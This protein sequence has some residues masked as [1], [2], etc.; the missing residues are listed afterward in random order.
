MAEI[1]IDLLR[2]RLHRV[3]EREG[4]QESDAL[5]DSLHQLQIALQQ[6][7]MMMIVEIPVARAA[8]IGIA[9]GRKGAHEIGG[10]RRLE[11][12]AQHPRGIGMA[13]GGG[14]FLAID[15]VAAI[16]GKRLA[17]P[18]LVVVGAR[19]GELARDAADLHHRHVGAEG[20]DR[21]HAQENAERVADIVGAELGEALGAVPALQQERLALGHRGQIGGEV[22]RLAGEDQ[23]RIGP[24][25]AFHG[26]KRRLVLVFRDL[27][28]RLLTPA[29][30][31]PGHGTI[32]CSACGYR[33]TGPS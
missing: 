17:A 4:A 21:R 9:A 26:R 31:A 18:R 7:G 22:A 27:T 28:D 8:E 25:L 11:I 19:L 13:R 2:A 5:L 23:R 15:D 16:G 29:L 30:R 14:E 1:E 10:R 24:K 32:S 33:R 20:Q 12:G 6:I 3:G